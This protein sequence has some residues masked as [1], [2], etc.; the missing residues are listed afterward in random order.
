MT[1]RA[2]A[3]AQAQVSFVTFSADVAQDIAGQGQGLI[4]NGDILFSLPA[5]KW[6]FTLGA[7]TD[8]DQQQKYMR[9]FFGVT[10]RL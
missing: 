2:R 8:V 9:T 7:G 10:P 5:G 6:L 4:A 3:F 1:V